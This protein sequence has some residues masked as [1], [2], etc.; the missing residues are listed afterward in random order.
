MAEVTLDTSRISDWKSFHEV[1]AECFGFPSF[2]GHN[3]NA[4]ID[5][6]TY[7]DEGDGMSRF[8]LAPDEDLRIYL[9]NYESF[10]AT[11]A[12]I[13][14]ELLLCVSFVNLR[15]VERQVRPRLALILL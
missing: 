3:M 13:C 14:Q 4:W 10:A 2:Y 1:C 7:L 5:C 12:D 6:L 8:V 15:S 9:S 11:H